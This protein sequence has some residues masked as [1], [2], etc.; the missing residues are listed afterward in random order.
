MPVRVVT[1]VLAALL[2]AVC[3]A[4]SDPPTRRPV[5]LHRV[6][7]EASA[8]TAYS[9]R[10]ARSVVPL[11]VAIAAVVSPRAS[12]Q[13]YDDLLTYLSERLDRPVHKIQRST[14]SEVNGLI[15]HGGAD[16]GLVCTLAYV[17]GNRDFGMELLAAPVVRGEQV[18]HSYIIVPSDSTADD[19]DD[20]RGKVF[21]FTDPLSNSGR[22]SPLFALHQLGHTPDTFFDRY[23]FTY[24]HD[25]SVRAVA[26]RFV[27]AA[28]VDS[29]IYDTMARSDSTIASRLKIIRTSPPYGIPP[30]VVHPAMEPQTKDDVRN[31]FFEMDQDPTG[32]RILAT[33]EIDRFAPA[34]DAAYDSIR[35]MMA[36]VDL[37]L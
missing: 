10:P 23:I 21:A 22:L 30:V 34:D 17:L 7:E 26:D 5:R 11:R 28:A 25:N 3:M 2:I 36:T 24:S 6:A 37:G 33:L 18:Y 15:R 20:L 35:E 14:Y 8:D 32:R 9:I 1:H 4:C 12:Y 27:D 31:V 16:V 29:L 19:I 13:Y